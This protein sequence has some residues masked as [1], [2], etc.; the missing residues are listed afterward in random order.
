MD[1]RLLRLPPAPRHDP[2]KDGN[3]FRWI[4]ET[5]PKV[6]EQNRQLHAQHR[7]MMR[8]SEE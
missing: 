8:D 1:N 5:A 2:A 4:V 3:P 6:R 7:Q